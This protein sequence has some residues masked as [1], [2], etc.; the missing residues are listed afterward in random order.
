MGPSV[1]VVE[2]ELELRVILEDNLEYEGYRVVSADTGEKAVALALSEPVS[3]V[4]LDVMLPG[5]SGYDVCRKL[6]TNGL[7]VPI[8]MITRAQYRA[9]SHR[10]PRARRR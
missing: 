4:L 6:R 9:R 7:N 3:L 5:M 8:I 10:G 1:M 2:D